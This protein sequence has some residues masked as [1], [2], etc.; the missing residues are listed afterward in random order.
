MI[1]W[2]SGAMDYITK[3]NVVTHVIG[4][5]LC[6]FAA[7]YIWLIKPGDATGAGVIVGAGTALVGIGHW[8]SQ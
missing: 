2:L 1:T 7:L 5:A 6:L 8:K 4:V 3:Y